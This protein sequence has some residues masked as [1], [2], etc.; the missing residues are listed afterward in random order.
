[1]SGDIPT[2]DDG[3]LGRVSCGSTGTRRRASGGNVGFE[4]RPR[5]ER[6]CEAAAVSTPPWSSVCAMILFLLPSTRICRHPSL[7]ARIGADRVT[8]P[9]CRC[10]RC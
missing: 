1:M 6:A 10:P 7:E 8:L 2:G 4:A 5:V 9:V 3:V